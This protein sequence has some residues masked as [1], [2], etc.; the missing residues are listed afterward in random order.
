MGN[1]TMG[2]R[3]RF[4]TSEQIKQIIGT[5]MY[6]CG[7]EFTVAEM[8]ATCNKVTC[9]QRMNALMQEMFSIG[10]VDKV[11]EG[12]IV[13]F[14]KPMASLLR[15]RWVSET[16]QNLCAGDTSGTLTGEAARA[17][18]LRARALAATGQEACGN[19]L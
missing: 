13:R 16:A 4:S 11:K 8:L 17:S 5:Q 2:K 1:S 18:F 15:Q 19:S 14:K 6:Q 3:P 9:T 12:V 10:L 7:D